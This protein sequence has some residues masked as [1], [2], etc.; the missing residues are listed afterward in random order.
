MMKSRNVYGVRLTT[1]V[2]VALCVA[3]LIAACGPPPACGD[4]IGDYVVCPACHTLN[5]PD[6]EYCI[7]CGARLH[8]EEAPPPAFRIV[9]F[10]VAPTACYGYNLPGPG[11]AFRG[12]KRKWSYGLSYQF[13]PVSVEGYEWALWSTEDDIH[14]LRAS[15]AFYLGS[16]KR[17][18]PY[19]GAVLE[20]RYQHIASNHYGTHGLYEHQ[21]FIATQV[22]AGVNLIYAAN[23]SNLELAL[24]LG[25]YTWWEAGPAKGIQVWG[26]ATSLNVANVTYLIPHVGVWGEIATGTSMFRP[27]QSG[28]VMTAGPALGW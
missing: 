11:M 16:R 5:P 2:E 17:V 4:E 25:P 20:G 28:T 21:F 13:F 15:S 6:A 22:S 8:P 23:G 27:S 26:L 18:T 14:R 1:A 24:S 10:T 3:T 9:P 19:V 12:D 7:R